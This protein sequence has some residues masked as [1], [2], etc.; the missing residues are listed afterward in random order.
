MVVTR[1]DVERAVASAGSKPDRT[2][3]LGALIARATG[4]EVVVVAGSAIEIYT[5]G[6]TSTLDID[7]VTPR[8]RAIRAVESWGFVR[9]GRVW[10][11]EDWKLD[12]DFLGSNLTGSRLKLRTYD[13]PYGPVRVAAVEDLLVRR[14]AEL[15]HW[16][17]TPKWRND[18]IKQVRILVA[19]YD[20]KMDEEYL[21]IIARR[22]NVLDI[23]ADFRRH[24]GVSTSARSPAAAAAAT[25]RRE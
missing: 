14:L 5:S 10:R 18:L 20:D 4:D 16:P 13:T 24:A 2:L 7:L 9:T 6:R 25:L 12:I 8:K 23:L 17:T 19:E 1:E 11:R 21:G 22:E 15:K 3:V